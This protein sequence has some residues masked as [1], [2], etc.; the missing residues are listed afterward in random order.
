[1]LEYNTER[2]ELIIKEYGRNIQKMIEFA[3]TIKDD[4]KRTETANA[5]VKVMSQI[6]PDTTDINHNPKKPSES[7]DYWNKLWDHLFIISNYQLNV[8]A[9]F[10]KPK[11]KAEKS[12]HIQAE[13]RK[14]PIRYRTYG[15]NMEQ[16]IKTV[17]QYPE[18]DRNK[19]VKI[20][21]N[22]LKKLYLTY[23]RDSV[24]DQL[25]VKQ[26]FDLSNG[27]LLVPDEFTL[28]ATRDIL[29]QKPQLKISNGKSKN[30][31]KNKNAGK[32]N[33]NS[34]NNKKKKKQ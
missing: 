25:I 7:P 9:P 11:P 32:N 24:D 33:N 12:K 18:E 29:R 26:L 28:D 30:N 5:I 2:N 8:D 4:K 22:H 19:L 21:A 6:N 15:R 23:N 31:G 20:L 16:I 10:P 1:M 3:C 17:A 13:Y 27:K 14:N 34:N